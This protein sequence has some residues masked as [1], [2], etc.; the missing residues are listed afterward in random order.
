MVKI[1][2][3]YACLDKNQIDWNIVPLPRVSDRPS[4]LIQLIQFFKLMSKNI[5]ILSLLFS[6]QW[7]FK[8]M[9]YRLTFFCVYTNWIK[10][11]IQINS[12][13]V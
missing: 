2:I 6:T 10:W 1:H 11:L 3:S 5:F 13:S 8:V 12:E 7:Y 4:I 9:I